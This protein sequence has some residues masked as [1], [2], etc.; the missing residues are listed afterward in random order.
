MG[1]AKGASQPFCYKAWYHA[2]LSDVNV[3]P[4]SG[5]QAGLPLWSSDDFSCALRMK[6]HLNS[7]ESPQ[8]Q[9]LNGPDIDIRPIDKQ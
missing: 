7:C 1:I 2:V 3:T 5:P 8:A 4:W 9:L 6:N